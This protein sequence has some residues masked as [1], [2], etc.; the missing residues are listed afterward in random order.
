MNAYSRWKFTVLFGCLLLAALVH[1]VVL[2]HV[3]GK[4]A[5]VLTMSF[6]FIAGILSLT[7]NRWQQLVGIVL[8]IIAICMRWLDLFVPGKKG[9]HF[10][11]SAKLVEITFFSLTV[12]M[13]M[14]AI[15][16]RRSVSVD[17]ILGA[18]AGYLLIA[19]IWGL[20]FSLV[21]LLFPGAFHASDPLDPE[22]SSS[23][24]NRDWLLG[25]F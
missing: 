5:F 3:Y 13:L 12:V 20:G 6:F 25:Y 16:K 11:T 15:F 19:L 21:E 2:T 14:I 7:R 17:S 22:W 8:G 23:S 9:I 18:F 1:P 4:A 10:E 24:D